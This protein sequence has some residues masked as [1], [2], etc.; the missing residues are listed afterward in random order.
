MT[1]ELK[2][3][4]LKSIHCLGMLLAMFL[5]I[6]VSAF[7][8]TKEDVTDDNIRIAVDT[9]LWIDNV[10]T[11]NTIDVTVA[12]GIVR[13]E[14]TVNNLL[15]KE[16]AQAIAES[17]VGVR[18]VVN[19]VD[20]KPEVIPANDTLAQRVENAWLA[21]PAADSYE[22]TA[23]AGNG[24]VTLTG[25]VDSYAEREIAETVAK[26]VRGVIG[27]D[28]QIDINVKA[29]RPDTEIEIEVEKRLRNDVR[30]D[31]SLV[32]VNVNNG[33][34]NLSGT[35]GTAQEKNDAYTCAWVA[36]VSS[37]KT[38]NLEVKWWARDDMR[39]KKTFVSLSD[40]EIEAAVK[41]AFL[42]DPRVFSFE[43][44]VSVSNGTVTLSGTVDNLAARKAAAKDARNTL[45]VWRVKNQLKVRTDVPTNQE[46]EK[47]VATALVNDPYV[48]RYEINIDAYNGWV[49][50]SGQVNTSY[51]RARAKDVAEGV[52]GAL[53][54]VNNITFE[55]IWVYKTDWEIRAEVKDQLAWSPFVDSED[56]TV[57]VSQ[58]T[59]TLT[60]EVDSWSEW[61]SAQQNA[62]EAGARNVINNL[63]V[64]YPYY[65]PTGPVY[66][67]AYGFYS[68]TT[69]D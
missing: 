38:D 35:V 66:Y 12:E 17:I 51:E 32:D 30:V 5:L 39:R 20:V 54:V 67:G 52:K 24:K 23:V 53:G 48:M 56:V 40:K 11:A 57:S 31:D 37:V 61:E 21:D 8:L 64:E 68:Q 22:L 47:R 15:A 18:S 10:V 65:G 27:I 19:M 26:G 16:R 14:G 46:L 3:L 59:V 7:S 63:S 44:E 42:Y 62:Y 25:T 45:G 9:D 43:P 33:K 28:N 49:Y 13:L 4:K 69:S 1:Y 60:G 58:G 36:G 41:D 50:L 2:T 34:V 6:S 55:N 29:D